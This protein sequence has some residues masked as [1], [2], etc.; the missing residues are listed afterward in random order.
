M[1]FMQG[2]DKRKGKSM[3]FWQY[4]IQTVDESESVNKNIWICH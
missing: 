4:K 2:C 3:L 1:Y